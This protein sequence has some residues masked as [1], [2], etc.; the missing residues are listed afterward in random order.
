MADRRSAALFGKVFKYLAEDGSEKAKLFAKDL[1]EKTYE[2]DF[3]SYQIEQDESLI[4][5]GLAAVK[6]DGVVR[7]EGDE[8]FE[9]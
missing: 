7:Y 9:E 6:K 2:Y 5:L 1:W 4:S 3:C 8:G